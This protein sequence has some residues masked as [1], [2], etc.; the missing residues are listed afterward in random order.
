MPSWL[1]AR[2]QVGAAMASYWHET[3]AWPAGQPCPPCIVDPTKLIYLAYILSCN[4]DDG[5]KYSASEERTF[6]RTCKSRVLCLYREYSAG[7]LVRV[8][9]SISSFSCLR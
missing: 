2:A 7:I 8:N 9:L 4:S 1:P 3:K 5:G 6:S